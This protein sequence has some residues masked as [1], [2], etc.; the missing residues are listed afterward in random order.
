MAE[1]I[2]GT[3]FDAELELTH[4]ICYGYHLP[5]LSIFKSN[6]IFMDKNNSPYNSPVKF[7]SKPLQSG[8]LHKRYAAM[9]P[10]AAVV[11]I[12]ALGRG[13]VISMADNPNFRAFWFGMNRLF[14]NAIFFGEVIAAR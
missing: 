5:K 1:D 3:I 12:D 14:I 4:P 13:K 6:A 10:N 7:T 8:Y 2:P 11:N 9:A